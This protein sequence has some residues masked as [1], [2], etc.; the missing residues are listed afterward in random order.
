MFSKGAAFVVAPLVMLAGARAEGL[1]I[2]GGLR[3]P[4]SPMP[5]TRWFVFALALAALGLGGLEGLERGH[6]RTLASARRGSEWVADAA[7]MFVLGAIALFASRYLMARPYP[8]LGVLTGVTVVGIGAS[9]LLHRFGGLAAGHDH[10]ER[11]LLAAGWL[12]GPAAV[13]VLLSAG[14]LHEAVAGSFLIGAYCAGL[15]VGM[16]GQRMSDARD[17]MTG[18]G[19]DGSGRTRWLPVCSAGLVM[20]VG[21]IEAW[22]GLAATSLPT[23]LTATHGLGSLVFVVG[24]GLVLG[25][26]HSTDADHVVAISTIVS[27]QRSIRG[28]AF[29]GSVWGIGH[30]ITIFVVGSL[31]ILFNVE[32]PVRL[33][34]SMEFSVAVML[35]LLG[36][37]NLTGLVQ[38]VTERFTQKDGM[39]DAAGNVAADGQGF[40]DR[41]LRWTVGRYGV[42]QF[43]RPLVIGLVHGLAGSAAVALLVLS[44]IHDPVWATFYLLVFGVG[45]L[46]GMMCMTAAIAVPLRYVGGRSTKIGQYLNF[47]SGMASLCF[48]SFLMYQLGFVGGLFGGHP[49]WTP[50]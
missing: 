21:T 34:L 33:G 8:W 30:T 24:L 1:A 46:V 20:I 19:G 42:Y 23:H 25:M 4:L 43:V 49:Q 15:A 37:T 11:R 32:I 2:A 5:G 7:W 50:R 6:E 38:R 31:I 9:M 47:A 26:R 35:V 14:V 36:I 39:P 16:I 28:A 10:A 29:I 27:K 40:Q 12:P 17:G 18:A 3:G 44:T 41:M 22:Q 45:T 48:G 13:A